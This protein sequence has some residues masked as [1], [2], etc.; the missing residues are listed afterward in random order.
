MPAF[1]AP[2]GRMWARV[3]KQAARTG[4]LFIDDMGRSV[5]EERVHK[6]IVRGVQT[7]AP[8]AGETG[9]RKQKTPKRV[10][11]AFCLNGANMLFQ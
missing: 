4:C 7:R 10:S 5:S 11:F 6:K 8:A 3:S 9:T 1:K 2:M